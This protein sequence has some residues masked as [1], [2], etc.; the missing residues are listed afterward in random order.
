MRKSWLGLVFLVGSTVV[1]TNPNAPPRDPTSSEEAPSLLHRVAESSNG[2]VVFPPRDDERHGRPPMPTDLSSRGGDGQVRVV[3]PQ[4]DDKGRFDVTQDRFRLVFNQAMKRPD[5]PKATAPTKPGAPAPAID[6]APGTLVLSPPVPGTTRWIDAHTLEFAAARPLAL[7]KELEV[8]LGALTTTTGEALTEPFKATLVPRATVAGKVLSHVPV[9]GE[10]RVVV[11]KPWDGAK[12]GR[13]P[14]LHV[15]FDQPIDLGLAHALVE[16]HDAKGKR[17]PVR[18]DHPKGPTFEGVR[19]DPRFV[20]LATPVAPLTP[21]ESYDLAASDRFR[22]ADRAP[23]TTSFGVAE[24]LAQADVDCGWSRSELC[25]LEGTTL[26]TSARTVRL[27]FNNPI[28]TSGKELA[29]RVAVVP[30][31]KNLS[32]HSAGWGGEGEIEI[33]AAFDPATTYR[34]SVQGIRDAFDDVLVKPIALAI[35]TTPSSASV[36]MPEGVLML[37]EAGARRFPVTTRNVAEAELRFW[38]VKAGDATALDEARGHVRARTL[39]DGAPA[40]V[41]P[42]RPAAEREKSVDTT[43]DLT[44][45]LA[46]DTAYVATVALAKPAFG[47]QPIEFPQGSEAA[48]PIVALVTPASGKTLAIHARVVADAT[49]VHVARLT[50]G[51]PVAGATVLPRADGAKPVTTDALGIALLAGVSSGAVDVRAGDVSASAELDGGT[52]AKQLFPH[53]VGGAE[54]GPLDRRAMVLT[55]RGIYRPGSKVFVKATVRRPEG[56]KLVPVVDEGAVVKLVGP[57][58]DE[59]FR[60]EGRTSATGSVAMTVELPADAKLGRHQVVVERAGVEGPPLARTVVQV[61]EFEPPRFAVDVDAAAVGEAK[62]KATVRARY[63]FGAAM[64]GGVIAWTLRRQPAAL[65]AGPLVDAGLSFVPAP[66]YDDDETQSA[67]WTRSGEGNLGPDGSF[68]LEQAVAMTGTVGPQQV[69]VEADVSDGSHRHVA[70]RA[71]AV[72]H[73]APRYA[74]LKVD[75]RWTALRKPVPVQLGVVDTEGKAV[76]GAKATAK[77]MRL[78]WRFAQRRGAG[79]SARREWIVER[80]EAGS[81]SIT[82][83][84]RPVSCEL[85]PTSYGD[86][87]IVAQVDGRRGGSTSLWAWDD[88]DRGTR[89]PAPSRGRTLE[90][91]TDKSRYVPGERAKLLVHNPYPAATAILTLEQ[92][93]ILSHVE[94]R[95]TGPAALFEVPIETA[96]APFVHATVTLLPIAVAGGAPIASYRIGAARIPVSLSGARLDVAVNSLRQS[97]AP[98]EEAEVDIAVTD[99]GRAEADAEVAVAVVDEGVLRL[100]SFHAIDPAAMLRPGRALDFHMVDGRDALA[101]LTERSHVAG[102]GGG[103][104]STIRSTRKHF[105]ETA[106]FKPDVRTDGSGHARVR[107]R[108]PDNLTQF[109][110]MAVALDGEGKGAAAE[111]DFVVNKPVMVIPV[112]PRFATVGDRFEAAAMVHNNGDRPRS[113]VAH[114]GDRQVPVE[115]APNGHQRVAFDMKAEAPGAMT[116]AFAVTEPGGAPLDAVESKIPVDVPGLDER[117]QVHGSFS[118]RRVVELEI[119]E[120]ARGLGREVVTVRVGEHLW[121]ELGA[122]LEY[123]LDYP[124]GCVEQTTSSTLPLLAARDILPRIGLMHVTDADL[125]KKIRVGLDRLA[126]M[127]TAGGGLAYWPG[128]DE[129][130]VYGTA[131][132]MRAVVL[133]KHSGVELPRG[134]LEGMQTYLTE[135]LLAA[136]GGA[137]QAGGSAVDPEVQAAIAQSLAE[138][139]ALPPSATDALFERR[140]EQGVFGLSSLAM[141]LGTLPS[142]KDR[143][144]ELLDMVEASFDADGKPRSD[145]RLFDGWHYYGSPTRSRA[146]AAMALGKLRRSSRPLPLLLGDLAQQVESYTTQATAFSLLALASELVQKVGSGSDVRATLDGK[147]LAVTRDLGLGSRELEIP[148]G[149]LRGRKASLLL[150]TASDT[151]VGYR[152]T[153]SWRRTAAGD[154]GLVATTAKRGPDVWRVYTDPKGGAVDLAHVKAGDVLRVAVLARMPRT[155]Q[156]ER[157]GYLAVTDR[158]PA[159]F[160]PVQPDLATVATVPNLG[161]QH[162]LASVLRWGENSA[163][164]VELH[165]DRVDLYFDRVWGDFVAASYLVRATTPGTFAVAPTSAELMYEA[166]S[167]SFGDAQTVVVR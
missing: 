57:T 82:T 32:I 139:G 8:E 135:A 100:T 67:T 152:V 109:R 68:G 91:A 66:V 78:E 74:G 145:A 56:D 96:H 113:L 130:N 39:P 122:R 7:G 93:G 86:F 155:T 123:L 158:L 76:V 136:R 95:V 161:D 89:K 31:P 75:A 94:K 103:E 36:T 108:L 148:L 37:D 115:V 121:P 5:P 167:R 104:D 151:A 138:L 22:P 1:C 142:Q 164:H 21:G 30:R 102:D 54:A 79:G 124:H 60:S 25:R 6:A 61:A 105:V 153:S 44:A 149:D 19:V 48:R 159:G 16:V 166:D 45:R 62:V 65:P 160:E 24:R 70:N 97:Y 71:S 72:L 15:L 120:D 117:P 128:G 11:V 13:V 132:A 127:R 18:L 12:V 23:T 106:F 55:D 134:L 112:V 162:P 147:P 137:K 33:T 58:G 77:L 41:V 52:T 10:H 140:H 126:S 143:V 131:Y 125:K 133:A 51:E 156:R 26:R 83:E 150:E 53:F 119:P 116:L 40:V 63:L 34:V 107:F 43:A 46:P 47:A 99:G 14:K 92:G 38:P 29:R 81:C 84:A 2:P 118:G 73:P 98:G 20:V 80:V 64:D 27:R 35:E 154:R 114:L 101:A 88:E 146:Q 144:S 90:I 4:L 87:E 59:V 3:E 165:D 49:L 28:A 157:I 9:I 163:S 85:V 69:T 42:V 17:V 141:A 110:V 111:S 50:T 129:P